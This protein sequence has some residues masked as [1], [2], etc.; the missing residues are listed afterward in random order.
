[1]FVQAIHARTGGI[2]VLDNVDETA[3]V[4]VRVVGLAQRA[5]QGLYPDQ[6]PA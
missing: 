6:T 5:D 1:M 2:L 4:R 3:S